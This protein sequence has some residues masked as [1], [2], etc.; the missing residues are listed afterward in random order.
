MKDVKFSKKR[1]FANDKVPFYSSAELNYGSEL[2]I[3]LNVLPILGPRRR[4]TAMTT[5]ATR[6][7]I[8]AYSTKP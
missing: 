7:R 5:M 1:D 4:I 6:A 3:V 8:I 2:A